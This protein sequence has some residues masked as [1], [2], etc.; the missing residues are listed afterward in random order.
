MAEAMEVCLDSPS[1]GWICCYEKIMS[2]KM[3][4]GVRRRAATRSR[5]PS[6]RDFVVYY[7]VGG[8][9]ALAL[10]LVAIV[11]DWSRATLLLGGVILVMVYV[12]VGLILLLGRSE[13]TSRA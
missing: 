1:P 4:A 3:R 12:P 2:V 13:P 8:V 5:E 7:G 6:R 10:G 11:L 9:L